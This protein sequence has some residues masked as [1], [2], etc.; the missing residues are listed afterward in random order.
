ML[1]GLLLALA[2]HLLWV[3]R[4][5]LALADDVEALVYNLHLDWTTDYAQA[6]YA[7]ADLVRPFRAA[8]RWGL[9]LPSTLALASA[10][11][12]LR[13]ILGRG[14]DPLPDAPPALRWLGLGSIALAAFPLSLGLAMWV[15]VEVY[16]WIEW[17]G[18]AEPLMQDLYNVLPFVLLPGVAL[19]GS[20]A[21]LASTAPRRSGLRNPLAFRRLGRLPGLAAGTA[22]ASPLLIAAFIGLF[23]APRVA[24]L[25]GRAIWA[26]TCGNCH[27]RPLALYFVKTPEEWAETVRTHREVEGI[28]LSE[29]EAADLHGYLSGMR[30]FDDAWAFRTRCQNCHGSTWR[31]WDSRTEEDWGDV[32]R[33]MARWSPY[34][35][36]PGVEEQLVRYLSE[37]KGTDANDFGLGARYDDYARVVEVCDPCHSLTYEAE[38]YAEAPR[39]TTYDMVVRMNQKLAEPL[40]DDELD[41]ITDDYLELLRAPDTFD[42]LFPH[43]LPEPRGGGL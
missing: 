13:E 32:V 18:H 3:D 33:R 40:S 17:Y 35:Y 8:L 11:F 5:A 20:L 38:R 36:A 41:T 23:H 22:I 43:D 26:P 9:L 6:W 34:F 27:E 2:A 15:A 25:P 19:V 42:R 37:H 14:P 29:A 30:G 1:V 24:D 4:F 39:A 12:R 21:V 7:N 28:E 31:R 16:A 10:G